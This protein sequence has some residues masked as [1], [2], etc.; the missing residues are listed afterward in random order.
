MNQIQLH[1][2]WNEDV[3][4]TISILKDLS[5]ELEKIKTQAAMNG[6]D[7]L[8]MPKL[9]DRLATYDIED[10]HESLEPVFQK[11]GTVYD[12]GE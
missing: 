6:L 3:D 5:A 8:E 2:E 9:L 4:N 1:K 10:L 12:R 7:D 11:V